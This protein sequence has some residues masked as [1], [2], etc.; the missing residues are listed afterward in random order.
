M[1][2][3]A[4]GARGTGGSAE[5]PW[6]SP[7]WTHGHQDGMGMDGHG[8]LPWPLSGFGAGFGA[9]TVAVVSAG[10]L[11]GAEETPQELWGLCLRWRIAPTSV[12]LKLQKELNWQERREGQEGISA[13]MLLDRLGVETA[14]AGCRR[15]E[16]HKY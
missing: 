14:A 15:N 16:I 9:G 4:Q 8:C 5:I 13:E 10:G 11:D 3:G 6:H 7:G 2:K 1:V 12:R